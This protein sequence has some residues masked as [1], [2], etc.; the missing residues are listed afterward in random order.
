M[1]DA[2]DRARAMRAQPKARLQCPTG[3]HGPGVVLYISA[4]GVKGWCW[5]GKVLRPLAIGQPL[6]A[7]RRISASSVES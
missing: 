5:C 1:S 6:I 3:E 2:L 4:K 7:S